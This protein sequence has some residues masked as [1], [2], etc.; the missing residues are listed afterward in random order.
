MKARTRIALTAAIVGAAAGTAYPFI[1][2]AL[3]C[4]APESEACVWGKSYL[5]LSL[6]ISIP[7]VGGVIA[8]V[9]YVFMSWQARR[10]VRN[11]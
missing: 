2:L 3:A 5:P 4:R 9:A 8:V 1:D 10:E 11:K 7:L 6:G